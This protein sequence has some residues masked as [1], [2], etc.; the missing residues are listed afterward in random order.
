MGSP[1]SP[2]S[3][4]AQSIAAVFSLWL[5]I[6]AIIFLIVAAGVTY[7]IARFRARTHADGEPR[8]IFGSPRLEIA[9]TVI[10]LLIV[11]GLFVATVR[12]MIAVDAPQ[13]TDRSPQVV[14]TGH[15]WWWE[16]RYPNGMVVPWDIHIPSGHRLRARIES[17]D[18]IH[19]F[20]VPELARKMDAVPGRWGYIWLEADTP[21]PY[22]GT[23]AEF[24][25]AEHAWM[26]FRVMA[27][28]Q[29]AYD[30]WVQREIQPSPEPTGI[31]ADGA[32]LFQSRKCADCHTVT[33]TAPSSGKAPS[34]AHIASREYLAGGIS[35]N[36][37][38]NLML[39]LTDPQAA[40]PGN[41]M[42]NTALTADERR[43]LL[44]F[45]ESLR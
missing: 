7:A 23:C 44:A 18:V 4:Q 40:K 34:I 33:A 43:A 42:P 22:S 25:G 31:A 35:P 29:P 8:Q 16:A 9:W 3:A 30:A 17:A 1:F 19:D 11:T 15:Q 12:V 32:K 24:C 28:P 2:H 5:V 14:I 38:D 27:D 6:A 13:D 45:L 39:W 21:G 10:P 20:W 41:R 26:R 36:T 37:P